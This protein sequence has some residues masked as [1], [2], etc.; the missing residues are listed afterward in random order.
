L[1]RIVYLFIQGW[2]NLQA[3]LLRSEPPPSAEKEV[4][5]SVPDAHSH[6]G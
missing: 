6:P 2:K 3:D 5:A 4:R 1:L